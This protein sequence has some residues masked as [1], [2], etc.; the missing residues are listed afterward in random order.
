[1]DLKKK[2][3]LCFDECH[4]NIHCIFFQ[5]TSEVC[6]TKSMF[7]FTLRIGN[8]QYMSTLL[9]FGALSLKTIYFPSASKVTSFIYI[10]SSFSS[11]TTAFFSTLLNMWQIV[12][13]HGNTAFGN[14]LFPMIKFNKDDFPALISPTE[15]FN[16]RS[17]GKFNLYNV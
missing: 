2:Y 4:R 5:K 12:D 8:G 3:S 9:Q 13:V 17:R 16:M 11:M 1:M 6:T 10:S 15:K 7:Y 14:I